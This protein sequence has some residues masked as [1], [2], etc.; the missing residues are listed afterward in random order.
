LASPGSDGRREGIPLPEPEIS[1]GGI[2]LSRLAAGTV[3][4]RLPGVLDQGEELRTVMELLGHSTIRLTADTY[5]HVLPAREATGAIDR[6]LGED[7]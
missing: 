3:A 1:A 4:P 6:L 5:G 2:R 7:R